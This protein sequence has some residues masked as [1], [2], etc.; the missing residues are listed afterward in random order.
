MSKEYEGDRVEGVFIEDFCIPEHCCPERSET[1]KFP[2][3]ADCLPPEEIEQLVKE[4]RIANELLLDLA[5]D[6]E[7]PP[8]EI[9]QRAFDG[10]EG[11]YVEVINNAGEKVEGRVY[12]SGFDFVVLHG[13]KHEKVI[14]YSQVFSINPCGRFAD[15]DHDAPFRDVEA[16]FRRDL[17][18]NFGEVV[19][20]SPKLIQLLFKL[21]F[22]IYMLFFEAKTITIQLEDSIIEGFVTDV[23][24]ETVDLKVGKEIKVIPLNKV[25]LVTKK[26][27]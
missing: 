2:S 25:E 18:F 6:G 22:N 27:S 5:L 11:L 17:T 9:F 15:P 12:L 23:N 7:R 24:K 1:P 14:P 20:G 4:I 16:C 8:E 26:L 13:E 19:S 3:Q 10:L 21:R